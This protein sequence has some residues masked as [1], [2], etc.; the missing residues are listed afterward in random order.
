MLSAVLLYVLNTFYGQK[1]YSSIASYAKSV[2]GVVLMIL[3]LVSASIFSD[4]MSIIIT[5]IIIDIIAVIVYIKQ[6]ISGIS[7]IKSFLNM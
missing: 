5:V 7:V 3:I 6:L 4:I 1:Y 2:F